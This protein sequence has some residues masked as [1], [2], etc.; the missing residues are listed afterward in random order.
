MN[1][2]NFISTKL[3]EM[4]GKNDQH[5]IGML[6]LAI[7]DADLDPDSFLNYQDYKAVIQDQ[8]VTR[9]KAVKIENAE[10]VSIDLVEILQEKQSLFTLIAK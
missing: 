5:C 8:L 9:L 10:S 2:I 1:L 3:S 4:T 7:K 6:R